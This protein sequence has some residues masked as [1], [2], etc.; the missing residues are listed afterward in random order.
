[1]RN[2]LSEDELK[3]ILQRRDKDIQK[4]TE[5]RNVLIMFYTC[6]TDLFYRINDLLVT[7]KSSYTLN[8]T[9]WLGFE[10]ILDEFGVLLEYANSCL[11]NIS[12]VYKCKQYS[13]TTTFRFV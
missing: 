8:T 9:E 11:Y 10:G 7:F 4:R 5:I 12:T 13:I 6:C 2:K 3:T 1:M